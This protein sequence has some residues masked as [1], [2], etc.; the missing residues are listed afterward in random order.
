MNT[1][2]YQFY[3]LGMASSYIDS[4]FKINDRAGE[5]YPSP[6]RLFKILRKHPN[7]FPFGDYSLISF[8]IED[9]TRRGIKLTEDQI[10]K[11]LGRYSQEYKDLTKKEKMTWYRLLVAQI[12]DSIEGG[13]I[14]NEHEKRSKTQKR[15]KYTAHA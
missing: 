9:M 7:F 10:K 12:K 11:M 3:D 15:Y 8:L 2:D 6:S 14:N 1:M 5:R 13:K 4:I